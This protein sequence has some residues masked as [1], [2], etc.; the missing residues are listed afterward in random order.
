M[1][2][3]FYA[4]TCQTCYATAEALGLPSLAR[5]AAKLTGWLVKVP[6]PRTG[7]CA[8]FCPKHHADAEPLLAEIRRRNPDWDGQL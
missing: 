4:A 5:E 7:V 1:I 3:R 2:T 6:M 8:D